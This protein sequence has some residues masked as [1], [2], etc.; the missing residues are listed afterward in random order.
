MTNHEVA[1]TDAG[2]TSDPPLPR[3]PLRVTFCGPI[4]AGGV[5]RI[6]SACNIAVNE[7]FPSLEIAFNSPGGYVSDGIFLY[8]YIRALPLTVRFHNLGSVSS[9]ATAVFCAGT[10]NT[11][12]PNALFLIHPVVTTPG[13]PV[14]TETWR[15]MLAYA[16][17]DEARVDAI[18]VRH[19]RIPPR[20]LADRRS[21]DVML[22][23]EQ[24][25]EFGLVESIAEF[26]LPPGEQL[27]NV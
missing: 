27:L 2:L 19:T 1:P 21:L 14:A 12:A 8:N 10:G 9:I 23:A 17:A 4:D 6:A 20:L 26:R 13:S 3:P 18:L 16:D 11:C 22:T 24:A 5:G 25:L 7:G 15:G